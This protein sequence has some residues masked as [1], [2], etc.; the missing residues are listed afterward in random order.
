[1]KI[2]VNIG[3]H[4]TATPIKADIDR[5]KIEV[6][7]NENTHDESSAFVKMSLHQAERLRDHLTELIDKIKGEAK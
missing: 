6:M 4:L 5:I 7:Q 3:C 1:M 2:N